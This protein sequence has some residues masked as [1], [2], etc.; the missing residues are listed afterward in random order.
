MEPNTSKNK[1][2]Q[3]LAENK[4]LKAKIKL[5][6]G[7]KTVGKSLRKTVGRMGSN[8]FLGKGLKR[9]FLRLFEEIPSGKVQKVTLAD[10]S[11]HLVWRLTRV[12][13]FTL[14]LG[15]IPF[16][17]LGIQTYILNSQNQL[18]LYQ[19]KRLDQQV[20]LEEGSRRSSLV[21]LMS[22]IMDK[23]GEELKAS[24]N[25]DR[26]LSDEL[27]GRIVS[28]S[29]A[30]RPYRYL[31][32][33][34]LIA[35]P[36]SPERGQLL[37][38]LTNSLLSKKS[39]DKLFERADFSY[40]DLQN[41][42]FEN[43]YLEGAKLEYSNFQGANFKDADLD[44]VKF[45][46][47]NLQE[48]TFEET[49]MTGIKFKEADLRNCTMTRVKMTDANL[50]DADFRHATLSGDFRRSIIDRF[51]IDSVTIGF[52]NVEG[53]EIHDAYMS[54]HVD[55]ANVI[56]I[57]EME[58]RDY[59]NENYAWKKRYISKNSKKDSIYFLAPK[60]VSIL[61]TMENCSKTVEEIILSSN[62]IQTLE[63]E[64]KAK[65]EKL[66]FKLE[67]SPFGDVNLGIPK[68]KIYRFRIT[69]DETS[70]V[71]TI[72]WIEFDP[73]QQTLKRVSFSET[74]DLDFNKT[75]LRNFPLDCQ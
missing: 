43:A 49:Y 63:K 10:V 8:F 14:C 55:T 26:T 2:D 6:E 58:A 48:T 71:S 22:N 72:G 9:S 42:N 12:G 33:D 69:T 52:L 45:T 70:A 5:L 61:S 13:I 64:T 21:F 56:G 16:F 40:A 65:K 30:F 39:Y 73:V 74:I 37:F 7:K 50:T 20:N 19:N 25:K 32:N 31:E 44:Y 51:H 18:L 28:L 60:K 53:I 1:L 27:I 34:E 66:L 67:A 47:A 4:K 54:G 46:G 62:N 75:L 15:I 29:K 23:I 38:S 35:Q 57:F 41:A 11:S 24:S 3:I 36:L 17:I 59:L 68:D